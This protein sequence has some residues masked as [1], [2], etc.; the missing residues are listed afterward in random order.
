MRRADVSALGAL[1]A[2]CR[3]D[4]GF[5]RGGVDS[6]GG[7]GADFFAFFAAGACVGCDALRK[8]SKSP[9]YFLQCAEGADQIVKDFRLITQRYEHGDGEPDGQ[10]GESYMVLTLADEHR[11]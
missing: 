7:G 5:F 2:Q 1:V 8:N 11:H 6:D 4:N 10:D 3:C 9:D